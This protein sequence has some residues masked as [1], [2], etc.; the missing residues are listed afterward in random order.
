MP[1]RTVRPRHVAAM[2]DDLQRAGLSPRR[3]AAVVDALHAVFAFAVERRLG[4]RASPSPDSARA[5][6]ARGGPRRR[7]PHVT[8]L[9]LGARL[10]FWTTWLVVIGFLV[11]LRRAP[12][13]ARMTPWQQRLAATA[14][15]TVPGI[16]VRLSGGPRPTRSSSSPTAPPSSRR[17]SCSRGRARRRRSTSRA[18]LVVAAVAFVAILPEYIVEVHFAFTGRADY[19]TAN[20]TGASRLLLGVCVA[21]PAA[22]ALLPR[23]WRPADRPDRARAR[24]SA[25]SS[26]S[27]RSPACGRCAACAPA[28]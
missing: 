9:A 6:R 27:S 8:M 10:A 5:G 3:E 26:R 28:S 22:V 1:V 4:R 23:R 20:L 15:G 21:L 19:V 13:R 18:A 14:A 11:L 25:S 24:R 7:R 17:R 12:R 16:L 2:L